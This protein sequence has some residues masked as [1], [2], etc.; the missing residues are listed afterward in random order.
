MSSVADSLGY[1]L[2][3]QSMLTVLLHWMCR[4]YVDQVDEEADSARKDAQAGFRLECAWV[5]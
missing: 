1:R 4:C 3:E 5:G 2:E